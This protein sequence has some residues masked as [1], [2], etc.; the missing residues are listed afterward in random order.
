MSGSD[1]FITTIR[2]GNKF[3]FIFS[4]IV[5]AVYISQLYKCGNATMG[6]LKIPVN[7]DIHAVVGR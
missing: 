3:I 7:P 1:Y 6:C 2:V 4:E 5:P